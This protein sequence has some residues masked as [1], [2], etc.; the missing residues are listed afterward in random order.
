VARGV[1]GVLGAALLAGC[2]GVPPAPSCPAEAAPLV[3][4]RIEPG[5]VVRRDIG[6]A[7]MRADAARVLEAGASGALATR[8]PLLRHYFGQSFTQTR[9]DARL[10]AAEV[11]LAGGRSCAVP[12]RIDLVLRFVRREMRIATETHADACVEHEV[13][14]HELRHVALDDAVIATSRPLLEA[15]ARE[16]ARG[17]L[18]AAAGSFEEAKA[19][20][21]ERLRGGVRAIYEEFEGA[22]HRRHRDEIDT[23]AEYA[24]VK[25]MCDGRAPALIARRS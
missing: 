10:V 22:R 15:R 24:R 12:Q 13:E 21:S 2:A 3:T 19:R 1:I 20:L 17:L 8:D 18:P 14:T 6:M 4:A 25:T 16:L 7:E 11:E 5:E 9:L 23:E